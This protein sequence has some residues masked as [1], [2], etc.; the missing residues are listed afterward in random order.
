MIDL[1]RTWLPQ[2]IGY[3]EALR[4][5]TLAAAWAEGDRSR[6]SVYYSGELSEQVF[7]DLDAENMISEARRVLGAESPLMAAL[8]SFIA[9]LKR[10]DDWTEA[11]VDTETW[12]RAQTIPPSVRGIFT[13]EEWRETL[14]ASET[15]VL[16]AE[17][18]GYGSKDFR[19]E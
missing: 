6:T 1:F 11:H 15:L 19:S 2:I 18:S 5:G 4:D 16:A 3:A 8:E 12:G 10:L 7:G 17:Q 13:S 14:S 9:A